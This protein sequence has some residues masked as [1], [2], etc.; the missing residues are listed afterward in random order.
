MIEINNVKVV[1]LKGDDKFLLL[2][3]VLEVSG[4]W[5]VLEQ[6][7]V[8]L[9]KPKGEFLIALK[10]NMMMAYSKTDK[11]VITDPE[12]VEHLINCLIKQGYTNIVVVESRNYGMWFKNRDVARESLRV[13]VVRTIELWI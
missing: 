8:E 4:F 9:G 2:E 7:F 12:L 13:I 6:R 11:S 3:R 10:P 1:S 5:E